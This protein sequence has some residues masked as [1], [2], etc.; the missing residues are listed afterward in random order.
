MRHRPIDWWG[1]EV[2]QWSRFAIERA[3]QRWWRMYR[4][5]RAITL[6]V[7]EAVL[8]ASVLAG[9]VTFLAAS[10]LAEKVKAEMAVLEQRTREKARSLELRRC[11]E[12]PDWCKRTQAAYPMAAEKASV[13]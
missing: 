12:W 13:R 6:R 10:N 7:A 11:L 5:R 4:W 3:S 2:E 1:R 8:A 9:L